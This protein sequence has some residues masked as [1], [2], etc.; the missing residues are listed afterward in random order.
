MKVTLSLPDDL[1]ERLTQSLKGTKQ[2]ME[3]LI[4]E[5][6]QILDAVRPGHRFILLHGSGL[7]DLERR[8]GRGVSGAPDLVTAFDKLSSLAVGDHRIE[9]S[10]AQLLQV[11]HRAQKMGISFDAYLKD[12]Y[13]RI[14]RYLEDE[15]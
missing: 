8:V 7:T 4:I 13:E 10:P 2:S 12:V 14:G 1:H 9:L 3:Q 5:R 11:Q 6:L 15:L